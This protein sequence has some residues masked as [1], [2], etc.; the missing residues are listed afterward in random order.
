M[1]R[2]TMDETSCAAPSS[3]SFHQCIKNRLLGKKSAYIFLLACFGVLFIIIGLIFYLY[4]MHFLIQ[5]LIA[6]VSLVK[7]SGPNYFLTIFTPF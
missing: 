1:T 6:E 2:T 4:L 7:L 5:K 3:S